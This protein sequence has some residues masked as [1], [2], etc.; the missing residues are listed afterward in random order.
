MSLQITAVRRYCEHKIHIVD[1]QTKTLC[2]KTI[3]RVSM[4]YHRVPRD[5]KVCKDCLA[6]IGSKM[7]A[8]FVGWDHVE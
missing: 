1:T 3:G 2:G 6:I 7:L 4:N 8:D 5:K